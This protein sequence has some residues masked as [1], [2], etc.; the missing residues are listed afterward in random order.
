MGK[1]HT[2]SLLVNIKKSSFKDIHHRTAFE[3][4]KIKKTATQRLLH[5][6]YHLIMCFQTLLVYV[7]KHTC[8]YI[9]TQ[10]YLYYFITYYSFL[11]NN[12]L[13]ILL[14]T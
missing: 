5:Y 6:Y 13:S 12:I 4:V 3:N 8:I 14:T 11:I 9:Y 1:R 2:H 10:I 7:H